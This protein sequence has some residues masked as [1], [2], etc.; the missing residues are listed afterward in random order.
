M[1]P[2]RKW[3]SRVVWFEGHYQDNEADRHKRLDTDSD[4][5]HRIRH[6]PPAVAFAHRFGSDAARNLCGLHVLSNSDLR[7]RLRSPIFA[8]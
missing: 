3:I 8:S 1:S 7:H 5:P 6:M 2:P 4:Q